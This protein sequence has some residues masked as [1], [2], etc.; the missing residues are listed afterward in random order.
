[1]YLRQDKR[2]CFSLLEFFEKSRWLLL[3]AA[4][5]TALIAL[6]PSLS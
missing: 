2:V 5:A 3:V 6:I 1:M 4:I